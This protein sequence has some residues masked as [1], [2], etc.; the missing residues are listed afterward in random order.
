MSLQFVKESTSDALTLNGIS[1]LP[2]YICVAH[3]RIIQIA[4]CKGEENVSD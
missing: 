1:K 2:F 4:I 3:D